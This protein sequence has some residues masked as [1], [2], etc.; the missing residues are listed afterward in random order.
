MEVGACSPYQM[1]HYLIQFEPEYRGEDVQ[2]INIQNYRT[3]LNT[4]L[5]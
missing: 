3:Q 2:Y 4:E 1:N 5:S